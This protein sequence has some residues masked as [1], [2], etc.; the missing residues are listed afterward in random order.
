MNRSRVLAWAA[1]AAV[2]GASAALAHVRLHNPSNGNPLFWGAPGAI[3][4]VINSTGSDNIPDGSHET[5]IRNSIRSWNDVSGTTMTLVEDSSSASQARADWVATDTHLVYF[6]EANASGFFPGGSGIVAITPVWFFSNGAI[7]D[8]DILF[9]GSQFTFTT[10]AASSAMDVEDVVTHELGHFLG[11]D[12]SGIVGAT[13]YPFVSGNVTAH[14]SLSDDEGNGMR[15]VYPAGAS[16]SL[17]GTI[18]RLSDSSAVP[19]AWVVARDANGRTRGA[20]LSDVSGNF[21]LRG[22]GAG[23]YTVYASPL[24]NPVSAGNLTAGHSIVTD[25]EPAFY[26]LSASVGATSTLA[27]GSLFV[28]I[29]VSVNLGLTGDALPVVAIADGVTRVITLRGSGLIFGSTLSVSDPAL[30]QGVTT[31]ST[32]L[33]QF[34]LT[35]PPGS[36]PGHVD[37]EVTQGGTG[38]LAV[39]PGAIEIVP[40]S[41]TVANISPANGTAA[42]GTAVTITGTNFRAGSR[43]VVGDQLYVDGDVGGARVVNSTTITLTTAATVV[44]VHDVVVLD[45]TGVEGRLASSYTVATTPVI[46]TTFPPVGASAGGTEIVLTGT[47]FLSGL[48]IRINGVTQ[49]NVTIESEDKLRITSEAG[50]PG[51]PYMME[52]QNSGGGLATSAFAYVAAADPELQMVTPSNGEDLGGETLRLV[53]TGFTVSTKIVFNADPDTGAGGTPAASVTFIDANNLDV[54]TPAHTAGAVSVLARNNSGQAD[55]VSAAFTFDSTASGG[56]GGGC[57]TE[58]VSGDPSQRLRDA[59]LGSAWL[60][61]L[62]LYLQMRATVSTRRMTRLRVSVH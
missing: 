13:M 36:A 49:N 33:V 48:A 41:P 8:A 12:H 27:L 25:F 1:A 54:E 32:S 31:F 38:D 5:S 60:L 39:L 3:S 11:L 20:D 53:G 37:V 16:A 62:A 45:S 57:H 7:T 19:G 2:I 30:T 15:D 4:I 44:G 21:E 14:R 61:L 50:V 26:G 40:P 34:Q 17:T 55:V 46:D 56:G 43:V 47:N 29:D 58:F 22:L 52:V 51:G 28:D 59:L 10:D 18:L 24:D 9:N 23:T 42:A 6:D 35:V